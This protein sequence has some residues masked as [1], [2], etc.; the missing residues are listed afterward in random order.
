MKHL[1]L[2]LSLAVALYEQSQTGRTSGKLQIH[3]APMTLE[4]EGGVPQPTSQP[5]IVALLC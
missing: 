4:P 3:P 5:S 1:L 2:L